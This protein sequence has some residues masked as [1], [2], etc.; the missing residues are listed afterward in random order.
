[1]IE[2]NRKRYVLDTSAILAYIEEEA[3]SDTVE[4]LLIRA[5][6]GEIDVYIAFI[7]LTEIFYIT[8]QEQGE[9]EA[10][11]RIE[12]VRSLPVKIDESHDELNMAAGRL[13]ARQRI[14][15]AD[16]YIAAVSQ[17]R[18]A[19]LVHKDPEFEKVAPAI[20]EQ[21]LPYKTM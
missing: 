3:G 8:L 15:L 2:N 19:I 12:L 4:N 13:K 20:T 16:S 17:L 14:S 21:R 18:D 9:K 7:T 10:R 6:T 5:T 11:Q 1:M